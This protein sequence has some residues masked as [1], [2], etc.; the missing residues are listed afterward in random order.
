MC[1]IYVLAQ[2][3]KP[4]FSSEK[5]GLGDAITKALHYFKEARTLIQIGTDLMA[6]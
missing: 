3:I 2:I 1:S 6:D 4:L 5:T